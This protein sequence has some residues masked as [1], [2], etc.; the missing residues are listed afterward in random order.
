VRR[1]A[2]A[3]TRTKRR[4]RRWSRLCPS[5]AR[6][7]RPPI[8]TLARRRGSMR[9]CSMAR[10]FFFLLVSMPTARPREA[11][12]ARASEAERHESDERPKRR[13]AVCSAAS[14]SGQKSGGGETCREARFVSVPLTPDFAPVHPGGHPISR[15]SARCVMSRLGYARLGRVARARA[16][17]HTEVDSKP[18]GVTF[19]QAR[20]GRRAT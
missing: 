15:R 4:T 10:S 2:K 11:A 18:N 8:S 7:R 6:C 20:C 17:L 5:A 13:G 16:A 14:T 1:V 12:K 3:A 9:A 19:S